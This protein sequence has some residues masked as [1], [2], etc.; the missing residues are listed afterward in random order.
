MNAWEDQQRALKG[1]ERKAKLEAAAALQSYRRLGLT[2]EEIKLATLREENRL[3]KQSAAEQL[4]GYRG[5]L[6]EEEAKLAAQRQEELRQK[7][8]LEEQLRTNGVTSS[9]DLVAHQDAI[10][11]MK[12]SGSVSEL[13]A[14]YASPSVPQLPVSSFGS[15]TSLLVPAQ[16]DFSPDAPDAVA[17]SYDYDAAA[18]QFA[19]TAASSSAADTVPS[20]I[21][22]TPVPVPT[23]GP[24]TS[25]TSIKS[26][27][28]FMFGILTA[29]DVD[30]ASHEERSRLVSRYLARADQIARLAIAE[31]PSYQSILPSLAYPVAGTIE[32]DHSRTDAHR[33][34][35]TVTISFS[36]PDEATARSFQSQ[37]IERV[38][39]A[40]S[41]GS[42]IRQ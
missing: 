30:T 11:L 31:S 21:V 1:Q 37:I 32:K 42:F 39:T 20:P 41:D 35:V 33:T 22:P 12:D 13:A 26:K 19:S 3:Q 34:R 2:E 36:A 9:H 25:T 15:S 29:A 7:K 6:S 40:I 8:S 16:P 38:R 5:Q 18:S 23:F 24:T 27:A 10:R 28:M 14:G 17:P 4:R